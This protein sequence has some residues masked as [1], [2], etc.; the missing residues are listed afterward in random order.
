[1]YLASATYDSASITIKSA[2]ARGTPVVLSTSKYHIF[3]SIFDW[4]AIGNLKHAGF[5]LAME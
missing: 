2:E 4:A 1:V 3:I 5:E